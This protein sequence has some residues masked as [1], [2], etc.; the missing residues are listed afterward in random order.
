MLLVIIADSLQQIAIH[1]YYDVYCLRMTKASG[2]LP[3]V[4]PLRHGPGIVHCVINTGEAGPV[5]L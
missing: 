3:G 4:G 1:V 5:I 2:A